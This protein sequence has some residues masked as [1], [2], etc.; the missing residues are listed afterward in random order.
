MYDYPCKHATRYIT[1]LYGERN[2]YCWKGTMRL[3]FIRH[4]LSLGNAEERFQG[5]AE[6]DL[7]DEGRAQAERL[8]QRFLRDSFEPTHVYS[9]P[10][11]RTKQTVEIVARSWGR[12]IEFW[13]DLM[14]HDVGIFSGLTWA[15]IDARHPE[16]A[17]RFRESRDWGIVQGAES[18]EAQRERARRVIETLLSRHANSDV[19][20]LFSHGGI[21]QRMLAELLGTDRAWGVSVRNTAIFDFT[22]DL[23][24]WSHD[25]Y[26]RH[27]I[28]LWRINLFNDASHLVG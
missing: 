14:E 11:S 17:R 8:Y 16:L 25:G 13:N 22:L 21:M 9:S 7:S 2:I 27:N 1:L 12:P 5:R 3:V 6:Y 23:E 4:G 20:A 28:F 24:R 18:I 19:V 26:S 15:E 10:Q